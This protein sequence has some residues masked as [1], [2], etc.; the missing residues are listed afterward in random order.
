MEA[1]RASY[2]DSSSSSDSDSES[3]SK[4]KSKTQDF[5]LP[6]PPLDLLNPPDSHITPDYLLGSQANRI[7]SFPHVDGNY[8][9]HVYIPVHIPAAPKKEMIQFLKRVVSQVQGL[10]VIDLDIPIDAL[11]KDEQKLDQIVMGREYHISLG[12]TVPV[13]VHQI[14]SII[15]MLRQRLQ[16][17]KRYL[18]DFSKWEVFV[19]DDRTRSFLS[20]EILA[21]GLVQIR[22]QI[23]AVNEVYKLHNLP[24][25]YEEAR[26]HISI[27][28]ALGDISESLEKAVGEGE[29][30]RGGGKKNMFSCEFSGIECKIGKKTHQICSRYKD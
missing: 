30:G 29:R 21:G 17:Q 12:R 14:D 1:L 10:Y 18:I 4:S 13:R 27:A 9:L 26:P 15:T 20:I 8:A 19:N 28:W 11:C 7:R 24:E 3:E 25:F 22:R 5:V 6:P 23:Q 2:G 16:I